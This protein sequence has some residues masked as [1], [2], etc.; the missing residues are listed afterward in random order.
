MMPGGFF[1]TDYK[2]S[3]LIH[4]ATTQQEN[5]E[6]ETML[7]IRWASNGQ[8][9]F[10]SERTRFAVDDQSYLLFNA[11]R[12]FSSTIQSDT[13]VE[14]YTLCFAE[15]MAEEVLRS[16]VT[17]ADHLLDMPRDAG[18]APVL[19]LEKTYLHDSLVS[20][21]LFRLQEQRDSDA[22]NC[23]WF[24]EQFHALL[25]ALLQSHRNVLGEIERLPAVRA[26]TRMELY[27]RL[28]RARDF[29]EASLSEPLTLNQIADAAWLS[30]HHF[31]RLFKQAFGETPHRYLTLQ[32]IERAKHL[33]ARTDNRITDICWEVG[34]DSQ[35]SFSLLFR[36]HV[37][38]PPIV[39]RS[40]AQ[41]R[42]ICPRP[43]Q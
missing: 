21:H 40:Q 3:L 31:L 22:A 18:K 20:P 32:R 33:L 43:P 11:G 25:F 2:Q 8:R 42:V 29:M 13:L 39:F 16:L 1:E 34:F 15:R 37:G 26:A 28:H 4:W 9:R 7:S 27:R 36:R 12:R 30:P 17:P 10:E 5:P 23:G 35:S 24:E 14:C 6:G 41:K 38:V 19:F